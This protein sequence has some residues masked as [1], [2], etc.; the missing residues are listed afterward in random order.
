M[1]KS[2]NGEVKA[3]PARSKRQDDRKLAPFEVQLSTDNSHFHDTQSG[4]GTR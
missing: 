3:I 4:Q 2:N 1:R